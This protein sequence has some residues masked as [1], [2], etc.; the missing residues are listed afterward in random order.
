MRPIEERPTQRLP[1]VRRVDAVETQLLPA[2][3]RASARRPR[4]GTHI[5]KSRRRAA[6]LA[7]AVMVVILL[8]VLAPLTLPFG[9]AS[10]VGPFSGSTPAHPASASTSPSSATGKPNLTWAT[11]WQNLAEQAYVNN[12]IAHMSLDQEIAQMILISFDGFTLPPGYAPLISQYG[13]GGAVLYAAPGADNI[14]SGPQ[15]Q[16]LVKSMQAQASIP[17]IIATDQE[18][19]NVNRLASIPGFENQPAAYAIGSQGDPSVAKHW[20]ELDGQELYQL[21]INVDFAPVVDVLNV[22]TGDIGWRAFGSTPQVVTQMA[23]AFLQGVQEGHHVVATLKH[24][25]GLGD[26]PV[27]PHQQLYTLTRSLTDLQ[28]IDWVPYKNLI[29]TGQV[30]MVMSTHVIL[31]AV[32]KTE[33]ASL[34]YPVLTRILRD[35]LGFKGVIV[36][37]GVYMQSLWQSCGCSSF[38]P[39]FLKLVEAGNDLIC[40]LWDYGSVQLFIQPIHDAVTN[41]TI[42]KQH[43]D[44]SVRRILMLKL[45]YGI[46]TTPHGSAA[47]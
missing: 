24:F 4:R 21:G 5:L 28:N 37:D 22:T 15:M 8:I 1:A 36:T 32:D 2:V 46:M 39:I 6:I 33:P 44:D 25:P 11:Q 42:S 3:S 7:V 41:G 16:A 19:G 45:K 40:S 17:L 13:V 26:V 31:A 10:A 20:G 30:D 35:Q 9:P 38:A 47:G 12:I 18:G 43:I 14:Q 29:A 27:D 23:G 34:S